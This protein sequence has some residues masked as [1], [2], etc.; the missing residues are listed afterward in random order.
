MNVED[1]LVELA[2]EK[3]DIE[4]YKFCVFKP[5]I[6]EE[7]KDYFS[8][9]AVLPFSL[10]WVSRM[11]IYGGF[12]NHLRTKYIRSDETVLGLTSLVKLKDNREQQHLPLIDF[13]CGKS[14]EDL[15][16]VYEELKRLKY[17]EGY[18]LDSGRSY[19]YIGANVFSDGE[20]NRFLE[21]VHEL[22]IVGHNWPRLQKDVGYAVLRLT[23]CPKRGKF[24]APRLIEK[25]EDVQLR[26]PGM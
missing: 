14:P 9:L 7:D 23:A 18:V 17:L 19:H 15:A 11:R 12:F 16:K 21:D 20:F 1:V 2:R 13:N 8:I 24:Q 3:E 6:K 22:D 26:F 10:F 4:A 25:I 5:Y